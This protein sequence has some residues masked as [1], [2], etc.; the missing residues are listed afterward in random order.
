MLSVVGLGLGRPKLWFPREED[1]M[2][3]RR[4][5]S[6]SKKKRVHFTFVPRKAGKRATKESTASIL[7]AMEKIKQ[8]R[9]SLARSR[10][11]RW[12]ERRR[13]EHRTEKLRKPPPRGHRFRVMQARG[14]SSEG[15][16][17]SEIWHDVGSECKF[18]EDSSIPLPP[19]LTLISNIFKSERLTKAARWV[20]EKT[21]EIMKLSRLVKRAQI[22]QEPLRK[23]AR[24]LLMEK[25]HVQSEN[26]FF[27]EYLTK[28]TDACRRQYE[29]LWED[30][31]Q[32][33]G[34]IQQRRQE[35]TS[36]Y[37]KQ[38]VELKGELLKKEEIQF[39][40]ER[41]LQELKDI[42][43]VREKQDIE[44]QA[45]QEQK[46]KAQAET[47]AKKREVVVQ[48]LQEKALLE[49]TLKEP[50]MTQLENEERKE[51][52][53]KAQ[54]L[55]SAAKKYAFEFYSGIR[56]ENQRFQKEILQ[57]S[58]QCQAL[59]ATYSQL[60]NQKQQ[61]EQERGYIDSLIRG[62]QR[63]HSRHNLCLKVQGAPKTTRN[64]LLGIK[65]KIHPQ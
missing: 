30:Y 14:A 45:L 2:G 26:K 3:S 58:R 49:K 54:A 40:M 64:P 37:A 42:S 9:A 23:E 18:A 63:M 19:Y 51:L 47:A 10:V 65:S 5:G 21:V 11:G 44:I 46:K 59:Q 43:L 60:E 48:F 13:T 28:K 36:K 8:L 27:E 31:L 35:S 16:S 34:E 6:R 50:D 22:L 56:R 4:Q 38:N 1:E 29:N 55:E 7:S 20:K 57:Q 52:S 41:Q 24:Q 12:A 25:L 62:R 39:Y 17:L 32:K 33:S 15:V 61:L 53:R